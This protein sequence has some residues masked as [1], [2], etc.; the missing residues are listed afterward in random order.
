MIDLSLVLWHLISVYVLE[1][2][3]GQGC[4][5]FRM[6]RSI[7]E[8]SSRTFFNFSTALLAALHVPRHN[9][10]E[11][12]TLQHKDLS[13][14]PTNQPTTPTEEKMATDNAIPLLDLSFPARSP[15]ETSL[16]ALPGSPT[17]MRS[18]STTTATAT[19]TSTD[20]SLP[21]TP[22]NTRNLSSSTP[23]HLEGNSDGTSDSEARKTAEKKLVRKL[24]TF[25]FP[26]LLAMC[27]FQAVDRA[28]IG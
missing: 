26:C 17:E 13:N 22:Q 25:L 6:D 15:S 5:F 9:T 23:S 2:K 1:D 3:T 21:V 11:H 14:Q 10:I 16:T 24:D 20:P 28:S 7:Y 27:L 8:K 4:V 12:R 19:S 18:S